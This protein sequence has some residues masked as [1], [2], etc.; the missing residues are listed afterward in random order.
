MARPAELQALN[1][2]FTGL[3]IDEKLFVSTL[4]KWNPEHRRSFRKSN[5]HLFVDGHYFERWDDHRVKLLKHE[6]MRFKNAVVLWAMHPWERDA[7]LIKEALVKDP[8]PHLVIVEV[9][10]TRSSEQLLGARR[11]YHSLYEHSI[12]EEVAIHIRGPKRKLLVALVSA[13]RFEGP[14]VKEDIARAEAKILANTIKHGDKKNPVEDDE[15]IRILS[16][17]SKAHLRALYKHYKEVS[18][19]NIVEDLAGF[20]PILKQTVECLCTPYAYFSKIVNEAMKPGADVN[21]K[22]GLTRVI[23]S[24]GDEDVKEIKDEYNKL[25]GVP[26]SKKIEETANGSYKDLL[27]SLISREN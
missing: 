5:P 12:E 6:F 9:A 10:C 16:T 1:H 21:I 23:I 18:G 8:E 14:N 25:Y 27:L 4:G 7:R 24:R 20:D 26:L 22:K 13:Y 19:T 17:R 2:A 15:V 3:G 11:A